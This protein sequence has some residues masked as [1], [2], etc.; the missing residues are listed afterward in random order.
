MWYEWKPRLCPHR[1]ALMVSNWL[2]CNSAREGFSDSENSYALGSHM[3]TFVHQGASINDWFISNCTLTATWRCERNARCQDGIWHGRRSDQSNWRA[4]VNQ[5]DDPFTP[6]GF[7]RTRFN[8]ASC[9][10]L[11]YNL[12]IF[13]VALRSG[14]KM[15]VCLIITLS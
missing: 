13:S 5:F 7:V 1:R 2:N 8:P 9:H 10:V 15:I 3:W 11:S 4:S 12:A 6:E 14:G